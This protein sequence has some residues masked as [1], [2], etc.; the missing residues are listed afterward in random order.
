MNTNKISLNA[1]SPELKE[2]LL[3]GKVLFSTALVSAGA[4]TMIS[5]DGVDKT[6]NN[7][8]SSASA[9]G[10]ECLEF[11]SHALFGTAD[12]NLTF[13]DAFHTQ[14]ESLGPGGVF[15][16][17]NK[18]YNT[19]YKEEWDAL[20]DVQKND[21]ISSID[22]LI[23]YD[24]IQHNDNSGNVK[25]IKID[26]NI[27]P[28]S[29]DISVASLTPEV[30]IESVSINM[31]TGKLSSNEF[32]EEP[33]STEV[34]PQPDAGFDDPFFNEVDDIMI[35]GGITTSLPTSDTED[36]DNL[37]DP[38]QVEIDFDDVLETNNQDIEIDNLTDPSLV[39]IVYED[40]LTD[41]SVEISNESDNISDPSIDHLQDINN[42]LNQ[43]YN[44][45]I[46]I[47]EADFDF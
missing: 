15:E 45:E 16:Y 30:G 19:F 6:N 20:S 39:D 8:V 34:A 35:D 41:P 5:A 26:V 23:D 40:N 14:R 22:R 2:K 44:S 4:L 25:S 18:F 37:V 27:D 1:I 13:G 29:G 36:L 46:T 47:D 10:D 33:E 32:T 9:V 31:G 17:H 11:K 21:Y 12:N 38:T 42:T 3:N 24:T 43:S 28:E 7:V